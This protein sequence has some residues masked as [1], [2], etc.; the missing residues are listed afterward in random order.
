[1]PPVPL[2]RHPVPQGDAGHRGAVR[3]H[4]VQHLLRT[5]GL[6]AILS[7]YNYIWI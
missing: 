2:L 3:L 6:H 7:I 5:Y 1:L 4:Q